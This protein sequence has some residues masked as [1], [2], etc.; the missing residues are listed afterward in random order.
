M[1]GWLLIIALLILGGLLSTLGDLLGSRV[2]KARLSIFKLRPKRTA[3]FITVLTGSFISAVS[4]GLM[5]LVSRQLRVGLFELDDLQNKLQQSRLELL[6]LQEERKKLERRIT[7]GEKEL[8]NLEKNL[9]ALRR[10]D[11]VITSGQSLATTTFQFE[12]IDQSKKEI[13]NLLQR[14]NLYSFL[15]IRPGDTPNRRILLVRKDHIERLE[16][17]ISKG[18]DWVINIRSAGNVLKGEN[19]VY[20]FPEVLQNRNIVK[21]DEV[22]SS[23]DFNDD[24]L[25][26]NAISRKIKLLLSSTLAEVKRRGSLSSELQINANEINKLVERIQ[27]RNYYILTLESIAIQSSYTAEKVSIK[28]KIKEDKFIDSYQDDYE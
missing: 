15:R 28:L 1:T 5:L 4:L 16:N 2:G 24:E 19:Y 21:K 25:S 3:V 6:P 23:I 13:E 22:I 27:K 18:G 7:N 17:I 12:N 11:V 9:I 8:K 14:A 20:G 10:G 26:R